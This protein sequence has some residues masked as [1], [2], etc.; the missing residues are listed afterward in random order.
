[1]PRDQ[2]QLYTLSSE[3][4]IRAAFGGSSNSQWRSSQHH[5]GALPLASAAARPQDARVPTWRGISISVTRAL[6]PP[7]LSKGLGVYTIAASS[8]H[9]LTPHRCPPRLGSGNSTQCIISRHFSISI[10][11]SQV[12]FSDP[13]TGLR[14]EGPLVDGWTYMAFESLAGWSLQDILRL[15]DFGYCMRTSLSPLS[16]A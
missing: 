1:V 5:M 12:P 10:W 11:Q 13:G 3:S 2:S 6:A 4:W 14:K 16:S 8:P 15:F 7:T 9:R